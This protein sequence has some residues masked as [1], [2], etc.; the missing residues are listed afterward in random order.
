[1]NCT[2]HYAYR[3]FSSGGIYALK[4]RLILCEMVAPAPIQAEIILHCFKTVGIKFFYILTHPRI[5]Q[6]I[7]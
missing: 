7:P 6:N 3:I 4:I 2:P 1:M 5:F